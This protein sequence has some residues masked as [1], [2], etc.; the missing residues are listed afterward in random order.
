LDRIDALSP[1]EGASTKAAKDI[2]SESHPS[3]TPEVSST[4]AFRFL[5]TRIQTEGKSDARHAVAAR[6]PDPQSV[7]LVV[8]AL[9]ATPGLAAGAHASIASIRP[10]RPFRAALAQCRARIT[11]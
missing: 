5:A 7:A 6:V 2:R 4:R 10:G 9:G 1:I 11:A 3:I 8:L